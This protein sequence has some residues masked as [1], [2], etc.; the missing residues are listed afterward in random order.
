MEDKLRVEAKNLV[1]QIKATRNKL[2]SANGD[3]DEFVLQGSSGTQAP[4]LLTEPKRRRL[5]KGH[6]GKVYAMHWGADNDVSSNPTKDML[7]SASQD[8][9][10]IVWNAATE[11]KINAIPLRS[12]WVMT[13]AF[14]PTKGELV[15]CGGL[16]NLCSI[17]KINTSNDGSAP[18]QYGAAQRAHKELAAHDGYLSCCRF[19]DR[20]TKIITSSGDSTCIMWDI[21][22][23]VSLSIFGDHNG[24]VMSVSMNPQDSNMFV[25]GS[26]DSTAAIWDIR[27]T[28]QKCIEQYYGHESDINS[29]HFCSSGKVFATGSDDSTCRLFDIRC[30]QIGEYGNDRILCGITSVATSSSGRLLFA[31]YDDYACYGWDTLYQSIGDDEESS[32]YCYEMCGA[33][34]H[35]NRVS[36]LG[37][38]STGEA[39]CTGSWD[40]YLHVW[41]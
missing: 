11:N 12:S 38:N 36:C 13:C 29:V 34:G 23:A 15:A 6:F 5:L 31:G 14:E 27:N 25:S 3:S 10:L 16:D 41:A 20:G 9:K 26:C 4:Q 21:Q 24:D 7:V 39:L 35:D 37:V 22:N 18:T 17:Y 32:N 8:G 19:F 2:K 1:E 30:G 28:E 40:T 33:L